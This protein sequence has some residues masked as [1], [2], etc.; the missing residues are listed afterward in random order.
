VLG[1][2]QFRTRERD[3]HLKDDPLRAVANR[4]SERIAAIMQGRK[5]TK[6][7]PLPSPTIRAGRPRRV[8]A[9]VTR[10]N[11]SPNLRPLK[12]S[13]SSDLREHAMTRTVT[14]PGFPQWWARPPRPPPVPALACGRSSKRGIER[15]RFLGSLS[16]R[17]ILFWAP[18]STLKDFMAAIKATRS[19]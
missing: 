4:T 5:D 6:V 11:G 13:F 3:V 8:T 16:V 1:H 15:R 9:N 2:R 14:R 18:P 10:N 12:W 17:V 7:V 19:S